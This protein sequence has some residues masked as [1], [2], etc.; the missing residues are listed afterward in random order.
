MIYRVRHETTY[1]YSEPVSVCHNLSHLVPRTAPRQTC[2][3]SNLFVDPVPEVVATHEDYFGNPTTFFTLQSPHR[4]LHM[5]ATH[6]I[7]LASSGFLDPLRTVPW[8]QVAE[9]L[10]SDRRPEV[11]GA[12]QF[13]FDSPHAAAGPTWA[14]YAAVSFR[15]GRPVLDAVLDLTDRIHTEFRY[16]AQATT[17]TT[18]LQEVFAKRAGVCQDFA[19][20]QL[21]CLRSLGLAARYVSGY[22]CTAP[23]PG[24]MRLRG[25]DASH[26]WIAVYCPPI[27]WVG[28]DPTNNVVPSES[29]ILLAWGRDF[30][31]VTP[32]KGVILGG[33]VHS[34]HVAVDV[35]PADEE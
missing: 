15:S 18:P 10:S 17:L 7:D 2:L 22:L 9:L 23:P 27:G 5:A 19:H 4:R 25:A 28:V 8:E 20:L 3:E 16:D 21:A 11:L 26:A 24:Q 34:V 31:D 6:T 1:Y 30:D 35:V 29:H 32:M 13:V 14:D 33:G 12:Y